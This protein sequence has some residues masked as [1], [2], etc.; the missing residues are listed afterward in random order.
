MSF[1]ILRINKTWL[2]SR[3]AQRAYLVAACMS[4][5][6]LQYFLAVALAEAYFGEEAVHKAGGLQILSRLVVLPGVIGFATLLVAMWYFWFNFDDSSSNKRVL[7]FLVL[8]LIPLGAI[9]YY[10]A[11]YRK[12]SRL[13]G[14]RPSA[15]QPAGT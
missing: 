8:A 12:S 10:A 7:W 2:L 3:A 13:E 15:L 1:Y 6:L 11:V 5:L 4:L 9:V 14:R